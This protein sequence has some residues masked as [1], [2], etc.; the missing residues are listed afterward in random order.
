M[1]MTLTKDDLQAIKTMF[2]EGIEEAKRHTAAGFAEVHEKFAKVN[3]KFAEV[4]QKFAKVNE[5]ID[6]LASDLKEVKQTVR[7]IEVVQKAE[8]ERVDKH[9]AKINKIRDSLR[10]I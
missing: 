4:H 5:K 9:E 2:E 6:N 1:H 3:E 8:I 10:T 7:R